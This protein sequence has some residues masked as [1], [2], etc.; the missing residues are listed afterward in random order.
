MRPAVKG[1]HLKPRLS[2][3]QNR[4]SLGLIRSGLVSDVFKQPPKM[5]DLLPRSQD[6]PEASAHTHLLP[7]KF[8]DQSR[9]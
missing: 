9:L 7:V 2:T 5:H 3:G 8:L 4:V 1:T 6:L